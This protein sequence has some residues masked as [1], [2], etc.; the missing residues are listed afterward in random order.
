MRTDQIGPGA[1]DPDD[2]RRDDA[3]GDVEGER[4]EATEER[5]AEVRARLDDGFYDRGPV[6][7]VVARRILR[8]GEV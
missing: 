5:L 2:P 3:L 4:P 1:R 8:S 7:D 6:L